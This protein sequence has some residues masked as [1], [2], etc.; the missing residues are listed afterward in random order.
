MRN[1]RRLKVNRQRNYRRVQGRGE[2]LEPRCVLAG[3]PL[4]ISE[5]MAANQS[6]TDRYSEYSDWIEIYNPT[7]QDLSLGAFR[8]MTDDPTL[9]QQWVFPDVSITAH[10]TQVVFATE[11]DRSIADS[12]I[13]ISN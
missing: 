7:N 9:P 5:F 8:A 13:R 3:E 4:L 12:C 6:L 10:G 11:R 1:S 2:L